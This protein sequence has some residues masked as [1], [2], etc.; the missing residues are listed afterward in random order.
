MKNKIKKIITTSLISAVSL[1]AIGCSSSNN[2]LA[3]NIDKSMAEFVSSI[4]KLDYVDT[5]TETSNDKIGKIVETSGSSSNG[6]SYLNEN[7]SELEIENTI[8]RPTERTDNFKLFVLSSRPYISLT[9]DDNSTSLDINLKFSTDLIEQTSDEINEKINTLI[10]KRSILMIYVNEIYNGN[11]TLTEENK[12]AINAYVNVIKENTSFLNGNRGMVKNQLGIASDLVESDKNESLV[13]YYIIKSGEALETRSNKIN[14]TISAIDSIIDILENNL[15]VNSTYYNTK[16]SSTYQNIL[17]NLKSEST[18]SNADS[19]NIEIA[20]KIA[21]SLNFKTDSA[22]TNNQ[23]S[24]QTTETP[25]NENTTTENT[26]NNIVN[27]PNTNNNTTTNP[28]IINNNYLK[29]NDLSINTPT[30]NVTNPNNNQNNSSDYLARNSQRRFQNNQNTTSLNSTQ[31]TNTESKQNT[32]DNQNL[33]TR[34]LTN[35][36]QENSNQNAIQNNEIT[37]TVHE[38]KIIRD[39]ANRQSKARRIRRRNANNNN[40]SNITPEEKDNPV[41]STG[42]NNAEVPKTLEENND[43]TLNNSVVRTTEE[44][45]KTTNNSKSHSNNNRATRVPYQSTSTFNN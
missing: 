23:L 20:N 45:T 29:T 7:I 43:R 13:N 39:T 12:V 38:N 14:S 34:Y 40:P 8:T 35:T 21:E 9:S 33:N 6:I 2:K 37:G 16:L 1:T 31:N 5:S 22:T 44:Y 19:S 41:V 28:Q 10:L 18:T 17:T 15:S 30:Q 32:T 36:N 24:N 42:N 25:T 11:V 27:N 26:T 4:N 3:K